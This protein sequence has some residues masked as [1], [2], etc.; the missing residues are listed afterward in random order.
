MSDIVIMLIIVSDFK[1]KF[2]LINIGVILIVIM[3]S[4]FFK[5]YVIVMIFFVIFCF[6]VNC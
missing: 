6:F 3:L 1:L 5:I 2:I 4:I